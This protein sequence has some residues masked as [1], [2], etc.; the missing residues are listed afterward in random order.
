MSAVAYEVKCG[1]NKI[2]TN[3]KIANTSYSI[4]NLKI[5]ACI[6][7]FAPLAAIAEWGGHLAYGSAR[8]KWCALKWWHLSFFDQFESQPFLFFNLLS[9]TKL[10]LNKFL[11][12]RLHQKKNWEK[13]LKLL[14]IGSNWLSQITHNNLFFRVLTRVPYSCLIWICYYCVLSQ[15]QYVW[16]PG[17]V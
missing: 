2:C 6:F 12:L 9:N 15:R 7:P 16:Q 13:V 3:L 14:V 8:H 17:L 10:F 5:L 1:S 11:L 4:Q